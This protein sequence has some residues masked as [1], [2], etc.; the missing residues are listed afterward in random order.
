MADY[1][2]TQ[3]SRAAREELKLIA[4]KAVITPSSDKDVATLSVKPLERGY[5]LTIG[6]ALRRV[7]LASLPGAAITSIQIDGIQHEFSSIPGVIEDVTGIV[8]NLKSVILKI[9]SEDAIE[10]NLEIDV[11]GPITVTAGDIICDE[12]VEII[13]KDQYIC[14]VNSGR[15]RI[16]LTARKG[17]GYK[18]ADENREYCESLAGVIPIDSIYTPV[19]KVAYHVNKVRIQDNANYEELVLDVTTNGSVTPEY[20]VAK[21]DMILKD[22]LDC[23]ASLSDRAVQ[24]GSTTGVSIVE[25]EESQTP[26]RPIEDLDLSVRSYNCL[27]RA[28]IYK[29]SDLCNKSE[30]DMMKIR[31]LGKK[32]LKEIK[33]KLEEMGL[34]FARY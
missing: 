24:E 30:E 27:K 12:E 8:L 23:V 17:I 10:K 1:D 21:A 15:L 22:Q 14:R 32:S 5:G 20:A 6:N 9:L 33:D 34:G 26:D 2:I 19:L 3:E 11:T 7:L 29:I 28:G 13:N 16:Q 31:N 25:S 18:N 4:P